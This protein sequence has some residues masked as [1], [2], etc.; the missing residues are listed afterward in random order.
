MLR[1]R[2]NTRISAISLSLNAGSTSTGWS[3]PEGW[4]CDATI[5]SFRDQS[6]EQ[7]P[8]RHCFAAARIPCSPR[9]KRPGITP[10]GTPIRIVLIP[11]FS[12][13]NAQGTSQAPNNGQYT[14]FFDGFPDTWQT[15]CLF[16][17]PYSFSIQWVPYNK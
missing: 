17:D 16:A 12:L 11:S 4:F 14:L 9:T 10:V 5:L 3:T 1:R 2:L 7:Y 13:T 15:P 6:A 8:I